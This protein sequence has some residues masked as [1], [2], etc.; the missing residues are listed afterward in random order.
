[1]IA[2]AFLL[3]W[4]ILLLLPRDWVGWAAAQLSPW[5]LWGGIYL[6]P[7]A[8]RLLFPLWLARRRD[9]SFR[10]LLPG[11][12]EWFREG[13]IAFVLFASVW[14]ILLAA[15]V[16]A[17]LVSEE[18]GAIPAV[19]SG[20]GRSAPWTATLLLLLSALTVAPL[21]EEIFFRGL[22]Y[23]WLLRYCPQLLALIVQAGIF[24]LLHPFDPIHLAIVFVFG[25]AL[26]VVYQWRQTLLAPIL[27]HAMQNVVATL[28]VLIL[29]E[30]MS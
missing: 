15:I 9:P 27:L 23:N 5:A 10:V 25:L 21:C 12:G 2:V 30:G 22:V 4:R 8:W 20:V 3:P 26:G 16:G 17:M 18:G 14:G 13:L 29:G 24:A 19:W 28:A 6:I 7:V 1:M 11:R